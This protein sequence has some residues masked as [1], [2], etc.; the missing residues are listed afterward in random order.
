MQND[1]FDIAKLE[2]LENKVKKLLEKFVEQ[3]QD[4]KEAQTE[5]EMLRKELDFKNKE[6]QIF[7]NHQKISKITDK[8]VL[9]S[10]SSTDFKNKINEY[11]KEIEKALS[12]LN[13]A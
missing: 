4:L 9:D 10:K 5:N 8:V 1:L 3:K 11:I 13:K 6:L 7:E 12:Y 2:Q